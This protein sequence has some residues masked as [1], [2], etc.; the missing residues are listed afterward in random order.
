MGKVTCKRVQRDWYRPALLWLNQ[1]KLLYPR[2]VGRDCRWWSEAP[3]LSQQINSSHFSV[4]MFILPGPFTACL[5]SMANS[6]QPKAARGRDELLW[7]PDRWFGRILPLP[8]SCPVTNTSIL[9][10]GFIP[11]RFQT[12][13][14]LPVKED[15]DKHLPGLTEFE[16]SCGSVESTLAERIP[17]KNPNLL[18]LASHFPSKWHRQTT[19]SPN[20]ELR[21]RRMGLIPQVYQNPHLRLREFILHAIGSNILFPY[22]CTE[23]NLLTICIAGE[24]LL[25]MLVWVF[26]LTTSSTALKSPSKTWSAAI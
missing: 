13:L 4:H 7:Q 12:R 22:C 9:S 19:W 8:S 2:A 1:L 21:D 23:V 20:W 5:Q 16:Q 24:Q 6:R 14:A 10:Q 26:F 11:S 17:T 15:A 25:A 3:F 18:H